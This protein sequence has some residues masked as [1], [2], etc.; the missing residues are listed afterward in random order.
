MWKGVRSQPFVVF[1]SISRGSALGR[2]AFDVV[3]G[4]VTVFHRYPSHAP[5]QVGTAETGE[6]SLFMGENPL[7]PGASKRS[8]PL[9]SCR[10]IEP[11]RDRFA[12]ARVREV[13]DGS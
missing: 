8:V 2:I 13:G 9:G 6:D 11:V 7:P 10:H 3:S 4:P 1:T 5:R 12:S